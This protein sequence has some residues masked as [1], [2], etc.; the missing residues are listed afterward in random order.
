MKR[1]TQLL[2]FTCGVLAPAP[3]LAQVPTAQGPTHAVQPAGAVKPMRWSMVAR[4]G[5]DSSTS[6]VP[7]TP[8]EVKRLIDAAVM[9]VT[10]LTRGHPLTL[11]GT[12]GTTK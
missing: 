5:T 2:F 8:A 12:V 6:A 9:R 10:D 1:P 4:Y 11:S 7:R 3:V